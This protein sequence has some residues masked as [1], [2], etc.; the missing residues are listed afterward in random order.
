MRFYREW[1]LANRDIFD[2]ICPDRVA[3]MIVTVSYV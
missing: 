2:A 1:Q 3:L